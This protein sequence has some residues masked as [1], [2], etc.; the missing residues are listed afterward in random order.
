M[1]LRTEDKRLDRLVVTVGA[2][3]I[4]AALFVLVGR[5]SGRPEW[6]RMWS[7]GPP[8]AFASALAF[9]ALGLG[10]IM[11]VRKWRWAAIVASVVPGI[12]GVTSLL[13][14]IQGV[15]AGTRPS[16]YDPTMPAV[17]ASVGV[18][19][20][21]APN[22][23]CALVLLSMALVNWANGVWRP[24]LTVTLSSIVV[25]I[26]GIA[27]A[28]FVTD[29]RTS[30]VWWRYTA[31]AIHT[32]VILALVGG[33]LVYWVMRRTPPEE[34]PGIRSFPFIALACT[35]VA[36]LAVV[37]IVSSEYQRATAEEVQ[38]ALGVR[39]AVEHFNLTDAE[40]DSAVAAS[41]LTGADPE[42]EAVTNGKSAV[43]EAVAAIT[44]VDPD[45]DAVR[46]AVAGL[47]AAC[48]DEF[49]ADS[50]RFDRVRHGQ[51][52]P[53]EAVS[54]RSSEEWSI[55]LTRV[56]A[57]LE[58]EIDRTVAMRQ[59][60]LNRRV[61][62]MRWVLGVGALLIAATLWAAF[63]LMNRARA[64][65]GDI[66]REL[67]R[68][69]ADR[70]RDFMFL[71][72]AM[73]QLVFTA[74]PD[75]KVESLN[76]R[77]LEYL[78]VTT[79]AEGLVQVMK[80]LH[81]DDSPG[82]LSA[83]AAMCRDGQPSG[84]ECR[85][86]NSHGEYR[87]HLW[88]AFPQR[89]ARGAIRRWVGTST[90]IDGQKNFADVLERNVTE[91]TAE[92]AASRERLQA[93]ADSLPMLIAHVDRGY[94]YQFVNQ[95]YETWL[96][97]NRADAVGHPARELLGEETW[98]VVEPALQR[99]MRG[100][101]NTLERTVKTARGSRNLKT[102]YIPEFDPAGAVQGCYI[103]SFDVT[104]AK[105]IELN[106]ARARD[107]ALAASRL[108]SDFMATV[109]HEIRTPMNGV[110]GMAAL[111]AEMPL[112]EDQRE[113]VRVI[114]QS[115]DSL[116]GVIN[117]ILDLAKIEAGTYALEITDFDFHEMARAI[118]TMFAARAAEKGLTLTFHV[119]AGLNHRVQGDPRRLR[120][121]L[122]NLVGN[123]VKFT[124]HGGI[125]IEVTA[126][127]TGEEGVE[128]YASVRDTGAGI[129]PDDQ[130]RLFSSFVQV[131]A[132]PEK[133]HGGTGLGLAICRQLIELM[134][135]KI[136]VESD[137]GAGSCFWFRVCLPW[138][139]TTGS[140]RRDLR[141]LVVD[142]DPHDR[143]MIGFYLAENGFKVDTASDGESA[144]AK[145]TASAGPL[146]WDLLL[147]DH[148][149]PGLDGVELA[150]RLSADDRGRALPFVLMSG[151]ALRGAGSALTTGVRAIVTKPIRQEEFDAALQACGLSGASVP[152]ASEQPES[153]AEAPRNCVLVVDD[154]DANLKVA[155]LTLE[156]LGQKVETASSGSEALER[157]RTGKYDLV[158][159]DCQMPGLSGYDTT[160]R[161][162]SRTIEG[163]NPDV[164]VV[165]L[166]AYA[167]AED[168]EKCREAG[169]SDYISKPIRV[170][171]L[172][173]AM[174]RAGLR[175]PP[176]PEPRSGPPAPAAPPSGPVILD[177]RYMRE[178][179]ALPGQ[180]RR[181]LWDDLLH[182]YREMSAG[183]L[184]RLVA[185]VQ[186]RDFPAIRE[187]AHR[188]AG[189]SAGIGAPATKAAAL[190]LEQAAD[191]SDPGALDQA[192]DGLK[193]AHARFHS[194]MDKISPP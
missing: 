151:G 70:T 9:V 122:T 188:F 21:M 167:M 168:A 55:T 104:D 54:L 23:A 40:L 137:R 150:R 48:R 186:T 115:A 155:R 14:A 91:R 169:M 139:A 172:H 15:Y 126:E 147:A 113:M 109:S 98:R 41:L 73:P 18:S 152:P 47:H 38:R 25:G 5:F 189:S 191:R 140:T 148:R 75:G 27:I 107:E 7:S 117:D 130:K 97:F 108:K 164:P 124:D 154:H 89:D 187:A 87:W 123:A 103:V 85:L 56:V 60:A 171:T 134:D 44:A 66:N 182:S 19:G 96:G 82:Q 58:A 166:T 193:A 26:A 62:E 39:L 79:E 67:E 158:L 1:P 183:H 84:G 35:L 159:M 111:L 42:R 106:L 68:R 179:Q 185:L 52:T 22:T 33:T 145:V 46:Q 101:A 112:G 144:L 90:D 149:M 119:D 16:L 69:V 72:D 63:S 49:A 31:M 135:G 127:A 142:D 153:A 143:E 61:A 157:L 163:I 53:A 83:W 81:P 156:R 136:G 94:R 116:L 170:P 88:R 59:V 80:S 95:A 131:D 146:P 114:E 13:L 3:V 24:R 177:R 110:V 64:Q 132:S 133:R 176:L 12:T 6:A 65:L 93:I 51:I 180:S 11:N 141:I 8:M 92:L 161:I 118:T 74:A 20:A 77:W 10:L 190:Q 178:M 102:Q 78:G 71:F 192:M 184:D 160:R 57:A 125:T 175:M 100:E 50:R 2:G 30:T 129:S 17:T 121:V 194:L 32:A 36:L 99:V 28:S 105:Q 4:A 43:L 162:R 173:A 29:L 76:Q 86:R 45:N 138:A 34:R 165:A 120:Q 181:T 37:T 174:L 128:V